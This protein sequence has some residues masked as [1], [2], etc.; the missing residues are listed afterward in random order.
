MLLV[1]KFGEK[2]LLWVNFQNETDHPVFVMSEQPANTQVFN[3][4]I[5]D[6][7]GSMRS[8]G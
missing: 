2:N 4:I 3:V 7:S 8:T 1:D 5:L 6:Q